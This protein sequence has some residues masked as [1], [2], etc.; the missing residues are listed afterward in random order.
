MKNLN[1]LDNFRVKTTRIL[2]LYGNYGD[3]TCGVFIIP[4]VIDRKSLYVIASTGG[5]WDHVSVSRE[6]RCPNWPEMEG[7]RKLFFE[8]NET[9]VQYHVPDDEHVNN[10]ST[11][12][13][14]WRYQSG[15]PKP[16]VEMVGV[17]GVELV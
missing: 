4:S 1:E 9:V 14:M 15:F 16:P 12:L 2:A 6:R 7:V 17:K 13:H 5:G 11:C 8:P 3:H 10:Y